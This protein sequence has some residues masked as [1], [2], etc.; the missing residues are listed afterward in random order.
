MPLENVQTQKSYK[1]LQEVETVAQDVL[2]L[3]QEKLQLANAHNKL[4]EALTGLKC[5]EDRTS[6][7]QKGCVY[8]ELPTEEIKSIVKDEIDKVEDGLNDLRNKIR[9]KSQELRDLEHQPRI[10]GLTL[11]PVSNIEAT[12]LNKAFGFN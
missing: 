6:W 11:K 8:I 9:A 4:R 1:Y 7:L 5:T 2:T 3:K 12:A 10:E